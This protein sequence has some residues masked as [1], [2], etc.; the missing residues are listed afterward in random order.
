MNPSS[1]VHDADRDPVD[2]LAEEFA[3]RIR[4]GETPAISEYVGRYP[5][6]AEQIQDLFPSI[7][8]LEQLGSHGHDDRNSTSRASHDHLPPHHQIGDFEILREI[9][10]GGM[11]VVY[12]AIQHSLRRLVALKVLNYG[13]VHSDKQGLRFEREARAAAQLHHTNIVP[14]FGVGEQDGHRYYVMQ[15]IHG[16]GL[17]SVLAELARKNRGSTPG[18]VSEGEGLSSVSAGELAAVLISSE[19]SNS[20]AAGINHS[21]ASKV[22]AGFESSGPVSPS[23]K[24]SP[25][26][27]GSRVFAHSSLILQDEESETLG[28]L[29]GQILTDTPDNSH[30]RSTSRPERRSLGRAETSSVARRTD[31]GRRYWRNIARVGV[32]VASGLQYAHSQGT[33]HRDIKPANVLLD[34]DGT[35]WI[36]DFGLAKVLESEDVTRSGDI[37]GTLRYMAPE[38]FRGESDARSDIYSLGLTLYEMLT[39]GPAYEETNRQK[40]LAHKLT[41]HDLPSL[42]KKVPQL[43]RDLD[44]IVLKC[45]AFES[46]NRYASAGALVA[47]LEAFLDDRPIRARQTSTVERLWRWCRRNPTVAALSGALASL[48][49]LIV[50]LTSAGFVHEQRLR[51]QADSERVKAERIADVAFEAFDSLGRSF[52]TDD[53]ATTIQFDEEGEAIGDEVRV[54]VISSETAAFLEQVR[55]AF[56]QL[57][58][59]AGTDDRFRDYAAKADLRAGELHLRMNQWSEAEEAFSRAIK[60]YESTASTQD[61][62]EIRLRLAKLYNGLGISTHSHSRHDE[63]R[64]AHE[65]A[66]TLL[67]GHI[68]QPEERFEL[69]RTHYLLGRWPFGPGSQ[70]PRSNRGIIRRV[71]ENRGHGSRH[72]GEQSEALQHPPRPPGPPHPESPPPPKPSE[73]RPDSGRT[74]DELQHLSTATDLFAELADEFPSS[75]EY[76]FWLAQCDLESSHHMPDQTGD[77]NDQRMTAIA[78][79][80]EL[81]E[82]H[83]DK[84]DYLYRLSEA[85]GQSYGE[86]NRLGHRIDEGESKQGEWVRPKDQAAQVEHDLREALRVSELLIRQQPHVPAYAVS[87]LFL[88]MALADVLRS[89][90]KPAQAR[91]YFEQAVAAR[92]SAVKNLPEMDGFFRGMEQAIEHLRVKQLMAEENYAA[93]KDVLTAILARYESDAQ[94]LSQRLG[95]EPRF[96]R[97]AEPVFRQLLTCH[98]KLG[99]FEEA[100][101]VRAVLAELRDDD[102]FNYWRESYRREVNER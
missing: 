89:E 101:E 63:S 7:A 2:V 51:E 70:G 10:R 11:G 26:A 80:E 16:L 14:V 83:P 60:M 29:S 4:R 61:N 36:A 57:A 5:D 94:R 100:D 18:H 53:F 23:A 15:R 97:R 73:R 76:R 58:D 85:Y 87:N 86:W 12:E 32:Q 71:R 78:L 72:E 77:N 25:S 56:D 1:Q 45:V 43:P 37:V 21:T 67:E 34:T 91:E 95:R 39:I 90:G 69:A 33:L 54:P 49:L 6:H 66:L 98:E 88:N 30:I 46:K 24:Q 99:E 31:L 28:P 64:E 17:D 59:V 22:Q 8:L 62:A 74:S 44:T 13:A 93:A 50:G 42:R 40:L 96:S 3:A 52:V 9:G 27:G 84:P 75:P 41:P 92:N 55:S 38:Q 79:L 48:L 82:A 47:D 20:T 102:R 68:K 65:R 81:V 35:A 19:L